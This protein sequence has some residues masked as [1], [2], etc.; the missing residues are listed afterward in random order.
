MVMFTEEESGFDL[1]NDVMEFT[2]ADVIKA[3]EG[4]PDDAVMCFVG[5]FDSFDIV[6]RWKRQLSDEEEQIVRDRRA[7][8]QAEIEAA[9]AH[10]RALGF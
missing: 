7:H 5:M 6:F 9:E 4:V 2:K 3:L 10:D 1:P 8:E